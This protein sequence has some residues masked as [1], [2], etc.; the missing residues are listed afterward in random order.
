MGAVAT[1]P[2]TQSV[3]VYVC[4]RGTEQRARRNTLAL[5]VDR[6]RT[7]KRS[8]LRV[9]RLPIAALV[10]ALAAACGG[11]PA[12]SPA[13]I[14]NSVPPTPPPDAAVGLPPRPLRVKL[15]VYADHACACADKACGTKVT[16]EVAGW[17]HDQAATGEYD[18]E[19]AAQPTFDMFECLRRLGVDT[20]PVSDAIDDLSLHARRRR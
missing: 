7:R 1:G 10:L 20:L 6:E 4:D 3:Y 2:R 13:P 11:T 15:R 16:S 5:S 17:L 19:G 8:G 12:P 14:G 9:F 18:D